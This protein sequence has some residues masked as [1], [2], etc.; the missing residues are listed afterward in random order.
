MA[1]Y[2]FLNPT[3]NLM[4]VAEYIKHCGRKVRLVTNNQFPPINASCIHV[5]HNGSYT[6]ARCTAA[7]VEVPSDLC[8]KIKKPLLPIMISNKISKELAA[9][10]QDFKRGNVNDLCLMKSGGVYTL[11]TPM[12]S[13]EPAA[14]QTL[15][16]EHPEA[17]IVTGYTE[18]ISGNEKIQMYDTDFDLKEA[19]GQDYFILFT[20]KE[21]IEICSH[22]NRLITLGRKNLEHIEILTASFPMLKHFSF[23]RVKELVISRNR[24]PWAVKMTDK[25]VVLLNDYSYFNLSLR[26]PSVWYEKVGKLLCLGKLR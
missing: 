16:N 11:D 24:Q 3:P 14:H 19:F 17:L 15:L 21:R 8:M 23:K 1:E 22:G 25:R 2:I 6:T 20:G 26:L 7:P 9:F 10:G 5:F 13:D 12:T 18:S 4:K